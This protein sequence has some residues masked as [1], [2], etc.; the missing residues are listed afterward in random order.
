MP[1]SQLA[2]QADAVRA[3]IARLEADLKKLLNTVGGAVGTAISGRISEPMKSIS[4]HIDPLLN[5]LGAASAP[6]KRGPGI[7][8]KAQGD[9]PKRRG[10]RGG[11]RKK[12][13]LT[14]EAIADA[15]KQT[16]GNKSAA[17]RALGVSQ[18]TFY[19]YLGLSEKATTTPAPSRPA[20]KRTRPTKKRTPKRKH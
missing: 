1:T 6:M 13:N 15:L 10:R 3:D 14:P 11:R 18:P 5:M 7:P 20:E 2:K 12:A 8:K 4:A 17:A 9:A 16:G 19:K